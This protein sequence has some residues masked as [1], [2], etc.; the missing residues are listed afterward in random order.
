MVGLRVMLKLDKNAIFFIFA[1][2]AMICMIIYGVNSGTEYKLFNTDGITLPLGRVI[3]VVSDN[4]EIDEHSLRRGKQVVNVE[5]LSGTRKGDII[6]VNNQLS[7]DHNVYVNEGQKI[8]VFL[9]QQPGDTHYYAT[10]QSYYRANTIVILIGIFLCLLALVGGKTGIRSAFGLSFTFTSIVFLMI[11]LI[12]SGAPP[13]WTSLLVILCITFVSLISTLGFSKKTWV[14]IAGTSIG[15][16]LCCIFFAGISYSLKITG[17]NVPEIDTLILIEQNTNIKVG[18]F[19]FVSVILSSLGAVF[20]VSVSVASSIAELSETKPSSTVKSLYQSGVRIG[21]D[22]IGATANTLIMALTGTSLI[23]II[24]FRFYHFDTNYI[25][26]MNEIALEL[27]QVLASTSA[28][29]L[30][31]PATAYLAAHLYGKQQ[32]KKPV[33]HR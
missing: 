24:M 26:N 2:L 19:L 3:E 18:D 20:D 25:I 22:I 31:A 16:I 11:P 28:L 30:C 5:L 6:E 12:L 13:V 4:T 27:M 9:D 23:S 8:V 1:V 29:I 7:I 33:K 32:L 15:V 17:Y 21:R 14:C 10:V